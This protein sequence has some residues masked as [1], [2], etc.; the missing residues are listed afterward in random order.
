MNIRND[1]IENNTSAS[2]FIQNPLING[3]LDIN[4]IN[5][6]NIFESNSINSSM[7]MRVNTQN[8]TSPFAVKPV[9]NIYINPTIAINV[10]SEDHIQSSVISMND[11]LG[12][13]ISSP[14]SNSHLILDQQP[15]ASIYSDQSFINNTLSIGAAVPVNYINNTN[16]FV[17]IDTS[18]QSYA[19]PSVTV[20]SSV[21]I[22]SDQSVINNTLSVDGV[23]CGNYIQNGLVVN[24]NTTVNPIF[25][26]DMERN[27]L[28]LS[29]P[30]NIYLQEEAEDNFSSPIDFHTETVAE[31][32]PSSL[33]L[34]VAITA[35]AFSAY[36]SNNN[37]SCSLQNGT[38]TSFLWDLFLLSV[39]IITYSATCNTVVKVFLNLRNKIKIFSNNTFSHNRFSFIFKICLHHKEKNYQIEERDAEINSA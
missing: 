38:S 2:N 28:T 21:S 30:K 22:Y 7:S 23:I 10:V 29:E 11:M 6:Y 27:F 37:L 12:S 31:N 9:N 14:F 33:F 17:S 8:I 39:N 15:L 26:N 35:L 25:G 24:A 1:I 20:Q 3:N 16:P 32:T 34:W 5:P 13:Q 18:F 4:S 36:S 19:S